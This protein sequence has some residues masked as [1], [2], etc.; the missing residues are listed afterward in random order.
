M[1]DQ[2]AHAIAAA[3]RAGVVRARAIVAEHLDRATEFPFLN[4]FT[5]LEAEAALQRADAI[6]AMVAAGEDPGPL[7]GVPLAVKDIID[8]AGLPT[9]AGSSFLREPALT[10]AP[11][12]ARF[13]AAGAVVIGRTGLHEFAFGFSSENDWFGPIRNPW[14]PTTSP[15]GSS[16]GSGAAVAAGAAPLALGTD[17]GGS[18]RVPAALCGVYGFKPTYGA[19]PLD[20]VFPLAAT[21][22][23]VGPLAQSAADLDLAFRVSANLVPGPAE[24]IDLRSLRIGV[25]RLWLD[26]PVDSRLLEAYDQAQHDTGAELIDVH[27]PS[28]VPPGEMPASFG[29]EVA[30]VHRAWFEADPER[31]GPEVRRRLAR[32]MEVTGADHRAALRWRDRLAGE[33]REAFGSV[34]AIATP[35]V[36]TARKPIGETYLEVAGVRLHYQEALSAFTAPVNHALLPAVAVPLAAAGNPPPSLQ[37][38]GPVGSDLRLLAVAAALEAAGIAAFRPPGEE[39]RTR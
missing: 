15:G 21:I 32:A 34:D 10:T 35:T 22:D 19:V 7:A 28:F 11:V 6:D 36:A 33:A 5:L 13:E 18:V 12:L 3:V 20:G 2:P 38:I 16:G 8:H 37:L 26:R 14:D 1:T 39:P 17:T 23:T 4:A 30:G 27:L 9:T 31:Y 29:Y 24:P 25:P